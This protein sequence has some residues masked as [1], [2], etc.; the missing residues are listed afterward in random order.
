ML[1]RGMPR[2]LVTTSSF[3]FVS[4]HVYQI[5]LPSSPAHAWIGTCR[6]V[7]LLQ[8]KS[9]RYNLVFFYRLTIIQASNCSSPCPIGL[10]SKEAVPTLFS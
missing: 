5:L 6:E 2:S 7:S 8:K 10:F 1:F 9:Q 3:I 4:C